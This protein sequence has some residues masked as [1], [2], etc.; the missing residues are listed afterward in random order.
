MSAHLP[1]DAGLA[2]VMKVGG[3][4]MCYRFLSR[5]LV[6]G[7]VLAPTS[8][9]AQAPIQD[10]VFYAGPDGITPSSVVGPTETGQLTVLR[11]RSFTTTPPDVTPA[12]F[13][14]DAGDPRRDGL[15]SQSI[16]FRSGPVLDNSRDPET[17]GTVTFPPE[18]TVVGVIGSTNS[19]A[20][21][22]ATD[23]SF[24]LAPD[25][26]YT[27]S[28]RRM[29]SGEFISVTQNADGS[30]TL[31]FR[32][33]INTTPFTDEF[34]VLIDHGD[35]FQGGVSVQVDLAVGDGINAG[36]E[37]HDGPSAQ[38]PL[39]DDDPPQDSDGDGLSDENEAQLGTDP[40]NPDSDG[41]G[42]PDG[43]ETEG[44]DPIDTDGDGDIDALDP[45]SDA[46]GIPD[47]VEGTVDSDDDERP[48][49][50]D[51]DDD[52]DGIP[53]RTETIPTDPAAGEIS[54]GMQF[55]DD[56]DGDG[57][58]NHL[59]TDADGDGDLDEDEGEGDEDGDQIPNYLDAV[60]DGPNGDPD[61]D[62]L[63]N[64]QEIDIGTSPVDP[65]SDG[66]GLSDADEVQDGATHGD[67][68][69]GDG[70][71]NW[72]DTDADGDGV[73]DGVEGRSDGD[74]DGIP[75][76]LDPV[77][78][79]PLDGGP[80]DGGAPPGDGGPGDGGVPPG[81]GGPGD[82]GAPG[83]DAG[84]LQPGDDGDYVPVDRDNCP[85]VKNP[86]QEDRDQDGIGDA[87]D[88]DA[89]GDGFDDD[90]VV[91]GG[92]CACGSSRGSDAT[93][94][95]ALCLA[96]LLS[97]RARRWLL[98][99]SQGGAALLVA[100]SLLGASQ[101]S[102]EKGSFPA[103]RLR[104]AMDREG[105]LDVESGAVHGHLDYDVGV[106]LG[107]ALNPLVLYRRGDD[108]RIQ[109]A[110]ALVGHRVGGNVVGAVSLFEWVELGVDLPVVLFQ[111][112]GDVP[113]GFSDDGLFFVGTGDLRLSPKI[114]V[115]R[116]EEQ[117]V[118][119]AVIPTLT[120][121]TG[122][123]LDEYMGE[124]FFT[125]V[126]EVAISRE[127]L[128]VKLAGNLA[129]RVRPESHLASLA[130]GHEVVYRA[131]VGYRLHETLQFP[132]EVDVSV[133]GAFGA[134][135]PPR[136]VNQVPLELLAGGGFDAFGPVQVFGGFGI[137]VLAGHGTPDLRLFAGV[138]V[139]ARGNDVDKDGI[140]D[141]LDRCPKRPE[142][143]DRFED[144][145]GCPEDDNDQDRILDVADRCPDVAGVPENEG[146]PAGDRDG[147]GVK[148]GDDECPEEPGVPERKGCPA[149][150]RDK[151]GVQ[152]DEDE[153]PDLAGEVRLMGC[154]DKDKDGIV[155][156]NDACPDEP[157]VVNG[158]NDDDGCPD[159]GK[160]TVI[161]R[162]SRIEIPERVYFDH[163]QATIQQRSLPLLKQVAGVLR[164]NAQITKVR[165]EGHTD[166][167]SSDEFNLQLSQQRAEAVRALLIQAGVHKDVL[168]A[169]G[170][171]E[172]KPVAD[173]ETEEGREKNRRV[174]FVI[175]ELDGK[176]V[177]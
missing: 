19:D 82:G 76:Y 166:S 94:F 58:P 134:L 6:A 124:G 106:W 51:D 72:R 172:S 165:I 64:E 8:S 100:L 145:D 53:T 141:D 46:D 44:G 92:G 49:Y 4:S 61:G 130:V 80:G 9:W 109:R 66:D 151:D 15:Y 43:V 105:I 167:T 81:D 95:A 60:S 150:D 30:T 12:G 173:N 125:L 93:L 112:R 152:D 97:R 45:D 98:G 156:P 155:D 79:P 140:I 41:D 47:A 38:I 65:D 70:L 5:L 119:L 164:A 68:V 128:G 7:V 142:D 25:L 29:E 18:V 129:Y 110:G 170:Y 56:V 96:L 123:P 59:D 175:V 103:E 35:A 177:Q 137:G 121:P 86:E 111:A 39:T 132:A 113:G 144:A 67:D 135:P 176:P 159:R 117:G 28:S 84:P 23:A 174:E 1:D 90:L 37:H 139:G 104:P 115:L 24:G 13:T 73:P 154:P 153:C 136:S 10:S 40:N 148:D 160:S 83:D 69:D 63:T 87:C 71:P 169:K 149:P 131:G 143:A 88:P 3:M 127:L 126:P 138:R 20:Q 22:V 32:C 27:A 36:T 120:I 33:Q 26:E 158:V 162:S 57:T 168:E 55:G 118:D 99:R 42:I 102:A 171:G 14:L 54:D 157:E 78:G 17:E 116:A 16:L 133:S 31:A 108:G 75:D 107:Y 21:L 114:R 50:R 74:G 163:G 85:D 101:A 52:D 62:G 48:D 34:R 146:C 91:Y 147:D 161:V 122:F 11:E 77:V 89:D 2:P